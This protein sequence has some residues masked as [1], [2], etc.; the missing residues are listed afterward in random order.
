[1]N[2][3]TEPSDLVFNIDQ[4]DQVGHVL[5][6][7]GLTKREYFAACALQG[8]CASNYTV[9]DRDIARYC[10]DLADELIN[11]LNKYIK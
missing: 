1:M 7:K 9:E 3:K 10:V 8:F 5:V 4:V 2:K 11:G 6:A